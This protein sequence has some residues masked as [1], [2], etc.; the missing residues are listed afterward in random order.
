MY[1]GFGFIPRHD[2]VQPPLRRHEQVRIRSHRGGKTRRTSQLC[3]E[4]AQWLFDTGGRAGP[5]DIWR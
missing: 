2:H 5:N 3:V 1:L 4:A